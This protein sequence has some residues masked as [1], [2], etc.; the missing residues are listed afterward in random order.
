MPCN[1]NGPPPKLAMFDSELEWALDSNVTWL[2]QPGTSTRNK[3]KY[4][5]WIFRMNPVSK[6]LRSMHLP[7]VKLQQALFHRNTNFYHLLT[8]I[9]N[10]DMHDPSTHSCLVRPVRVST[11]VLEA[12]S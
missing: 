2:K 1:R 11:R 10:K 4:N 8:P 7:R 6:L 12:E 3:L 9:R 5:P